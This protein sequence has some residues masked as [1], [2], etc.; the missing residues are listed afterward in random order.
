MIVARRDGNTYVAA[1]VAGGRLGV[2]L[3]G[4]HPT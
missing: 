3:R 4:A 1:A 2:E